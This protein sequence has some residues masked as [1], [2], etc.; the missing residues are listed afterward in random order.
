MQRRVVVL[1]FAVRP[2]LSEGSTG[3][4]QHAALDPVVRHAKD[5]EVALA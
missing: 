4:N 3:I 5:A 1:Q 2:Y